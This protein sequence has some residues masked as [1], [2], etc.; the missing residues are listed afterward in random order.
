MNCSGNLKKGAN[1]IGIEFRTSEYANQFLN[2]ESFSTKHAFT[3]Y[4]PQSLV[5]CRCMVK[6]IGDQINEED[7]L[8]ST[9]GQ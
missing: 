7:F 8:F 5:T 4:I 2:K 6:D 1:K 3:R 9:Y